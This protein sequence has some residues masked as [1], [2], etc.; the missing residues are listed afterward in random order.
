MTVL[1]LVLPYNT[2]HLLYF[3]YTFVINVIF[4]KP[5]TLQ[6]ANSIKT[7]CKELSAGLGDQREQLI[8]AL[9]A[10]VHGKTFD[11]KQYVIEALAELCA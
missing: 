2:L 1:G 9:L 11:G 8:R 3:F 5:F 7:I 4:R 6:A 10:A